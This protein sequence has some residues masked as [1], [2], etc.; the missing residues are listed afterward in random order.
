M[1]IIQLRK[2]LHIFI[3]EYLVLENIILWLHD[4]CMT[5]SFDL[6]IRLQICGSLCHINYIKYNTQ[7]YKKYSQLRPL[8]LCSD[9]FKWLIRNHSRVVKQVSSVT[10]WRFPAG[11]R[12]NSYCEFI[13]QEDCV[14]GSVHYFEQWSENS[15]YCTYLLVFSIKHPRAWKN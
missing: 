6:S 15:L 12:L 3:P 11:Q 9:V 10:S 8:N 1:H 5:A 14:Q 2:T 4:Y 13:C 7:Y